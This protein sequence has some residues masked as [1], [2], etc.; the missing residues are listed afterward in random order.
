MRLDLKSPNEIRWKQFFVVKW[1]RA[2]LNFCHLTSF[3]EEAKETN[4]SVKA[5][6]DV[7]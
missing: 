2:V 7:H 4:F 6:R 3:A 1:H 5:S